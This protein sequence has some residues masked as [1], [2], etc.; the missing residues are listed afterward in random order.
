M[1]CQD[2]WKYIELW[3]WKLAIF[4]INQKSKNYSVGFHPGKRKRGEQWWETKQ[5]KDK[6]MAKKVAITY[7]MRK[8][9]QAERER[10]TKYSGKLCI[11]RHTIYTSEIWSYRV[12]KIRHIV[13]INILLSDISLRNTELCMYF[14]WSNHKL[15]CN[16]N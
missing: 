13:I 6:W 4:I 15:S 3:K 12:F 9:H 7:I 8:L 10:T 11:W 5:K 1:I 2:V 16:C 14:W